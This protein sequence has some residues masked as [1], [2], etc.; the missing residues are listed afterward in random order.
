MLLMESDLEKLKA[1]IRRIK[2]S[3]PR[4]SKADLDKILKE[5]EMGRPKKAI[6]LATAS[7]KEL[8]VLGK[9]KKS[10]ILPKHLAK[11]LES[12]SANNEGATELDIVIEAL[13]EK[14]K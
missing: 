3:S 6:P 11:K 5:L 8:D 14:L 13:E 7:A 10:F 12:A 9:K 2:E 4:L 1:K